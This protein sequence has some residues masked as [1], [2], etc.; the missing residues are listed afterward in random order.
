MTSIHVLE[1]RPRIAAS[2]PA[3]VKRKFGPA[4]TGEDLATARIWYRLDICTLSQLIQHAKSMCVGYSLKV[5]NL[6]V[7]YEELQGFYESI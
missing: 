2:N 5:C 1:K 7:F 4:K 6:Q 3:P